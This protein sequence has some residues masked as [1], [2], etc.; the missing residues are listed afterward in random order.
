MTGTDRVADLLEWARGRLR[1]AGHEPREAAMLLARLLD[2]NEA[3][4]RAFGERPVVAKNAEL[5]RAL[6]RRRAMGE[7]A[8]YLLGEREFWGRDFFVDPRVLIPRPETEHLVEA[9]LAHSLPHTPTVVDVGTGSGC[10]AI[11]LAC[12]RPS[13]RVLATDLSMDALIIADHN[14]RRHEVRD[15]VGFLHTNLLA[16]VDLST[17]DLVVSNPP[18]VAQDGAVA[19]DVRAHEPHLA[20]FAE[21]HGRAIIEQLLDTAEHLRPGAAVMLE[22]GHD[23]SGWIRAAIDARPFL[24]NATMIRDYGNIERT[25]IVE[26]GTANEHGADS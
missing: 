19:D 2:L 17:I 13:W 10:I 8:A 1:D 3:H 21:R 9:A 11:T 24:I 14:A 20:L 12:E 15:R 7:P 5:F 4:V 16:G 23:Q 6:I 22:I 25:I 26:R 18:Y